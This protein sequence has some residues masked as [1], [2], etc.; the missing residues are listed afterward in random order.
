MAKRA[1]GVASFTLVGNTMTWTYGDGIAPTVFDLGSNPE[2]PGMSEFSQSVYRNGIKQKI[3][4][5]AAIQD[6]SVA[7]KAAAQRD[8]AAQLATLEW[9]GER[10]TLLAT[11]LQRLYPKSTPAE[12]ANTIK[13]C[14]KAELRGLENDLNVIQEIAKIRAERAKRAGID[15]SGIMA[16]F[17]K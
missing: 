10:S 15:V 5:A 14:N 13:G 7:E 12:I 8:V 17:K 2:Y 6:A 11:A 4:D 9:S 1:N 3:G 16:K